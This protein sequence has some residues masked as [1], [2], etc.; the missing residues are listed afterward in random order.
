MRW[1]LVLLWAL[2]SGVAVASEGNS[3]S[4]SSNDSNESS[5]N[6][7]ESSDNSN[8]S[9]DNSNESAKSSEE[10]GSS[11]DSSKNS[12]KDSTDKSSDDSSGDGNGAGTSSLVSL[13]VSAGVGLLFS[14]ILTVE[15]SND[16]NQNRSATLELQRFLRRYHPLVARDIGLAEGPILEAWTS[17]L[18]LKSAERQAFAFA[19]EGSAEQGQMMLALARGVSLDDTIR[20]ARALHGL[21]AKVMG[22]ERMRVLIAQAR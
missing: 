10:G 7:N 2:C 21:T 8:E 4:E 20:F 9:S 22:P 11:D 12:S 16:G 19:L 15:E 18:G 1:V 13:G 3:G 17:G 6:S 5:D 14:V